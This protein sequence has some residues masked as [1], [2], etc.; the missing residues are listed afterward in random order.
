MAPR[1]EQGPEP[2]LHEDSAPGS[3]VPAP[4]FREGPLSAQ[5]PQH[6]RGVGW[7]LAVGSTW[8]VRAGVLACPWEATSRSPLSFEGFT[9]PRTPTVETHGIAEGNHEWTGGRCPCSGWFS[10]GG[11]ALVLAPWVHGS[12]HPAHTL[13]SRTLETWSPRLGLA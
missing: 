9:S 3:Q 11:T 1:A 7:G 6:Q 10:T 13:P 12:R 4:I 2:V 8:H 5:P